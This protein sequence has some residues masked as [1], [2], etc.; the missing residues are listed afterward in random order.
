[1]M[2]FRNR[3]DAGEQ[4]A[5]ALSFFSNN[6]NTLVIGLPR[7]GIVVAAVVAKNLNLP[8]D[9]VCPRKIR[10]PLN[11]EYAIGATTEKGDGFIRDH[12][13]LTDVQIEKAFKREKSEA[14]RR[15]QFY[16]AG[17]PPRD[18][19]KKC[20]IIVDDGVATGAT[21]IAA[22]HTV[23]AEEASRIVVAVP[24]APHDCMRSI[25]DM[26]EV[27][28]AHAL[29]CPDP[30]FAVSNFYQD[31]SEVSDEIVRDILILAQNEKFGLG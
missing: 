7:G 13:T 2:K 5:K 11:P 3:I 27:H 18:L 24:V 28:E 17:M 9:I 23:E 29:F 31:F 22:I 6:P 21:M 16:R 25:E 12:T 20:V 8:L 15:V 19:R 4:L 1:M 26:I 10:S 14:I 30:F